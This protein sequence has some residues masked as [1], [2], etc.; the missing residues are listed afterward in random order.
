MKAIEFLRRKG[1]SNIK[2]SNENKIKKINQE[3]EYYLVDLLQEYALA[4][5][6]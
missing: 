1:L 2:I 4:I 6:L 5:T 3:D